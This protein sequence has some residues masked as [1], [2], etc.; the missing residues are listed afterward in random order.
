MPGSSGIRGLTGFKGNPGFTGPA[1][2]KGQKGDLGEKGQQGPFGFNGTKG[3]RGFKVLN[4]ED[5]FF[6]HSL[7]FE[8]TGGGDMSAHRQTMSAFTAFIQQPYPLENQP[9][10][11]LNVIS[12]QQ[13]HY[14]PLLGIYTA[15]V[16]G[17]YVFSFHLAV[18]NRVLK[19]GLF[20]NLFP[21]VR[22]TEANNQ[23]TASQTVVLHLTMGDQVWLQVKNGVTNGIYT[24][25]ESSST[26]SGYLL[27]PDSCELA[28]GRDFVVP[29]MYQMEDFSWDGPVST[30]MAP[31]EQNP[32]S[33][34]EPQV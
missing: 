29:P 34:S 7:L 9:I 12:N 32:V 8:Y 33:Q 3:E 27:Y 10:P 13:G 28:L 15:P 17:T 18:A 23:A 22:T 20:R 5:L 1:G 26:F 24:D 30:T 11:F 14:N 16:N 31:H 2:M 21:I 4:T 25:S 6:F 19:V